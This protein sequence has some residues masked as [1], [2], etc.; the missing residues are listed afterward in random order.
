MDETP[1]FILVGAVGPVSHDGRV[2]HVL[3]IE[4]HCCTGQGFLEML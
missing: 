1:E 2:C 3:H 4:V